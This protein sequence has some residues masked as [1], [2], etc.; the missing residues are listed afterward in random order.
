MTA[1]AVVDNLQIIAIGLENGVVLL[2]KSDSANK[3]YKISVIYEDS[4][5]ITGLSLVNSGADSFIYVVSYNRISIVPIAPS[6]ET[7]RTLDEGVGC[8]IG[9]SLLTPSEYPPEMVLARKE[10]IYFY[11]K[12]GRGPCFIIGGEKTDILWYKSYLVIVSVVPSLGEDVNLSSPIPS[13]SPTA[14]QLPFGSALH[15]GTVLSIYDLKTKLIA[16]RGTFGEET[17]D[18]K[19]GQNVGEEIIKVLA[20]PSELFVITKKNKVLYSI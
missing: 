1:I 3:N 5:P 19:C 17:F 8:E 15:M 14:T 7:S 12:E 6:K 10:A 4:T 18:P 16:F 20:G 11:G 2:L 9:N 13:V